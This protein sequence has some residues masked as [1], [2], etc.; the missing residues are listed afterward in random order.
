MP[1]SIS[2]SFSGCF[3]QK[4]DIFLGN[5][6]DVMPATMLTARLKKKPLVYDSHEFFLGMAGM[7]RKPFRRNIW[8]FIEIRIF[9]RLEI[10]VHRF[11]FHP[12]SVQEISIMKSFLLFVTFR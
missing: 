12:E 8:K 11:R 2:V 4:P 7:D 10:H 1:N 3:D 6:L 9:A 5:D